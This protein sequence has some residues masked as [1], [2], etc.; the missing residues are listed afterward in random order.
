MERIKQAL[1]RAKSERKQGIARAAALGEGASRQPNPS[2]HA[3]GRRSPL[4]EQQDRTQRNGESSQAAT[5]PVR[6]IQYTSTKTVDVAPRQL[7]ARH[8]ISGLESDVVTDSYRVLR[9]QVLRRLGQSNWNSIMVTSPARSEGKSLTAV[10]LS[11]SLAREVNHTVLLVDLDLRAPA[12]HKYF[13]YEPALSLLDVVEGRCALHE[14]LFNPGIQRLVVLPGSGRRID[15]SEVICSPPVVQLVD[16]IKQRYPTRIIIFDLPPVLTGDD[17][18]AFAPQADA[19][20][21]V[22]QDGK[23]RRDELIAAVENMG[24]IPLLGTVLNATREQMLK[25]Y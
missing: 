21:L 2:A 8:V 1:E 6:D 10:N 5:G 11:I 17:V 12:I 14:A 24:E 3:L 18:M 20:L 25:A 23:T 22:I 4:R 15:S 16:E 13:G 7:T 9:T 19:A